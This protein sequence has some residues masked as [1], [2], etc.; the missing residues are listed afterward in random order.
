M[1]D[2]SL[3][4]FLYANDEFF[5]LKDRSKAIGNAPNHGPIFGE[6]DIVTV[7]RNLANISRLKSYHPKGA[8]SKTKLV[9]HETFILEEYEAY[10][11][12]F[13]QPQ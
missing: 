9:P 13:H 4:S 7:D 11:V 5:I 2:N 3:D 10:S 6:T 8:A 1:S 12:C